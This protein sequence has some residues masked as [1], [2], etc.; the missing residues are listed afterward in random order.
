MGQM[1][2]PITI[3]M[4]AT[5]TPPAGMPGTVRSDPK[6]RLDE[7]LAAFQNYIAADDDY[8]GQIIVLE[9][10]D[11]DLTEF[12]RIARESGSRKKIQLINTS[13]DY[14]AQMGKGYGE[15]LM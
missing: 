14:P 6:L 13:S 2:E 5:I 1:L 11:S 9:N 15:I 3:L 10:S 12:E 4:T 8:V 7:Y